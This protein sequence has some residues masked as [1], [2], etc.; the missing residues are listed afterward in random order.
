MTESV[1]LHG[2]KNWTRAA[3]PCCPVCVGKVMPCRVR[4]VSGRKRHDCGLGS[5]KV[6]VYICHQITFSAR[7]MLTL[8]HCTAHDTDICNLGLSQPGAEQ[9]Q[10]AQGAPQADRQHYRSRLVRKCAGVLDQN[11]R[12]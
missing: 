11:R 5:G 1:F 8:S 4:D 3:P 12:E 10:E 9:E 2:D 7:A 6:D